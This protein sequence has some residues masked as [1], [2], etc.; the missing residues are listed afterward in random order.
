MD[1]IKAKLADLSAERDAA[2]DR[3]EEAEKGLRDAKLELARYEQEN[4]NLTNKVDKLEQDL[5]EA[6][7][8]VKEL[9]AQRQQATL[10]AEEAERGITS[11]EK[12]KEKIEADFDVRT[13]STFF[14]PRVLT[15]HTPVQK[16]KEKYNQVQ[17]E[18]QE[19]ESQLGGL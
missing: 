19:L 18:L 14:S 3:A 2:F 12:E 7:A 11:M 10:R 8:K 9:T 16:L 6:L 15:S 4:I 13:S 5:D 1:R 17:K